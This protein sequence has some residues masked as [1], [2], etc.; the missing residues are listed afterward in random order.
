VSDVERMLAFLRARVDEDEARALAT[1]HA[2]G[3]RTLAWRPTGGRRLTFDNGSWESYEAVR[4]GDWDRILVARDS[5]AGGPLAAHIARWD[6]ERVLAEVAAKR[7]ILE[8][9]SHPGRPV[10]QDSDDTMTV[11]LRLLAKPYADHPHY[12][13]GT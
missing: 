4:T 8:F 2:D 11:V 1:E 5:V 10:G 6:P 13:P 12:D 9:V 7:A 3:P